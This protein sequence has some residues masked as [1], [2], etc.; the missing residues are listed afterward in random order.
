ML[1]IVRLQLDA[2]R[3]LAYRSHRAVRALI[4][5]P[6]GHQVWGRDGL[7]MEA[8]GA[9]VA[10][11]VDI[12]AKVLPTGEYTLLLSGFTHDGDIKEIADYSFGIVTR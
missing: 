11:M 8:T 5:T 6:D 1:W 9:G 12:P 4:R 2:V 3:G 10:L 7:R